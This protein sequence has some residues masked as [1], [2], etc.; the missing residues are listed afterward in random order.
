MTVIEFLDKFA[1]EYSLEKEGSAVCVQEISAHKSGL[2]TEAARVV[3]IVAD[4]KNYM[5]VLPTYCVVDLGIIKDRLGASHVEF[6]DAGEEMSLFPRCQMGAESP[7]GILYGLPTL[8]DEL[9]DGDAYIVFQGE[10]CDRAISMPMSEY[11]RLASPRIFRFS[12][13]GS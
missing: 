8:M 1:A 9:L 13:P 2:S 5:C 3:V 6:V 4:G 7:F 12:Y 10:R 11:K